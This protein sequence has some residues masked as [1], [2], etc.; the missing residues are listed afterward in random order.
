MKDDWALI[1]NDIIDDND[2]D[3][4]NEDDKTIMPLIH[5]TLRTVVTTVMP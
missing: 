2:E 5:L 1:D 3:I 4:D